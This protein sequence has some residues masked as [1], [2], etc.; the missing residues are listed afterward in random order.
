MASACGAIDAHVSSSSAT[1]VT[2][3]KTVEGNEESK[4][5]SIFAGTEH[6]KPLIFLHNIY[7]LLAQSLQTMCVFLLS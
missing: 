7:S 5:E 6:P 2:T 3:A 1:E 4:I